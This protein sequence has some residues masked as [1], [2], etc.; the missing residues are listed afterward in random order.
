MLTKY[1]IFISETNKFI[2]R[3][4]NIPF[5]C[6]PPVSSKLQSTQHFNSS[7]GTH[8]MRCGIFCANL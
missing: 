2:I 6:A 1:L 5:I 7:T 4:N 3:I 8:V